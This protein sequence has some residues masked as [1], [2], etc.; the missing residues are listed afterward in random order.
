M[1]RKLAMADARSWILDAN[2]SSNASSQHRAPSIEHPAS[3]IQHRGATS[4]SGVSL[5]EVLIS[6]FVMLFGLMGVAAIFPVGNHYASRGDQYAR[7]AALAEAA[8]GE[9]EG[10]GLL[11][12]GV[13]LYAEA[14]RPGLSYIPGTTNEMAAN[15]IQ[16]SMA[17][18]PGLFNINPT[19]LG[20]GHAFVI[21]PLGVAEGRADG[22]SN[23]DAFPIAFFSDRQPGGT[24]TDG[25]QSDYP[26]IHPW[27]KPGASASTTAPLGI[28]G[29]RW[30]IRRVTLP[31]NDAYRPTMTPDVAAGM[32]RLHDDLTNETPEEG[33]RPGVQR[34]QRDG[35][36]APLSRQY[37]GNYSWL[38]TVV[39]T[40]RNGVAALQPWNYQYGSELYEV[41]VA[42]FYKRVPAPTA[43]SERSLEAQLNPGGE[44]IFYAANS[45]NGALAIDNAL[46]E[47]RP[48]HWIAL[49]GVNQSVP[50]TNQTGLFTLK[51]YRLLSLDDETQLDGARATRRAMLEGPDWPAPPGTGVVTNL[52]AIMMPG[53]IGVSTHMIPMDGHGSGRTSVF[54]KRF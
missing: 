23:L 50:I 3:S 9:L 5:L 22:V 44:L 24:I 14:P 53:I 25:Q 33:D 12:P 34:L 27:A 36:G 19:T 52:R 2:E 51:W 17:V 4:R 45:D 20:A 39:P 6:M 42:V 11:Q 46:N 32:V 15:V 8:F 10:R 47:M 16:H 54:S 38:A 28:D 7:G 26:N 30:P 31:T 13:W 43:E 41:S 48:G 18:S 1:K 49:A 21:D 37:T 35:T 40:S 29:K